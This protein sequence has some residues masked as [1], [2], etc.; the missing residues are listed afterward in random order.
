MLE[1]D[2]L[3]DWLARLGAAGEFAFDTETTSLDYMAARI[4]GVSFATEAGSA[5]SVA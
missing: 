4:V 3:D 1:A 2:R 5:A